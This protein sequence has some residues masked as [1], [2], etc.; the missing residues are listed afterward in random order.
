[1]NK[2]F[3]QYS[4]RINRFNLMIILFGAIILSKYFFIQ[5][6]TNTYL[7]SIIDDHGYKYRKSI[8]QRGKILDSNNNELA[9]TINK[10]TLWINTN[11]KNESERLI[12]ILA[13]AFKKDRSYYENKL[14]AN[15][16]YIVLE[17]DLNDNQY[18]KIIE[19]L[20]DLKNCGLSLVKR[21]M[22]IFYG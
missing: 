3:N 8:G 1:M 17:K 7:D 22:E 21:N 10:Y 9:N 16:S 6:K 20:E 14:I 18:N 11:I 2:Y 5:F 19:F 12:E 13:K 4:I 15:R